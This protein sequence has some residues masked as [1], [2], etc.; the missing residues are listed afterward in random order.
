[1]LTDG[2]GKHYAA[3]DPSE[4]G[5]TTNF[6]EGHLKGIRACNP[7]LGDVAPMPGQVLSAVDL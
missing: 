6:F 7:V 4:C 5:A 3:M 2:I 1:M